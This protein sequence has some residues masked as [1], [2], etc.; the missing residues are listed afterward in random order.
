MKFIKAVFEWAYIIVMFKET[1]DIAGD[2]NGAGM[3][4]DG[5]FSVEKCIHGDGSVQF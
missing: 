2:G 3:F 5:N 1:G 4:F